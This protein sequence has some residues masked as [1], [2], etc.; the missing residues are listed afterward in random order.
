MLC[1]VERRLKA[2]FVAETGAMSIIL[3]GSP[4]FYIGLK[5]ADEMQS[6]MIVHVEKNH[7]MPAL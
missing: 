5:N 4:F 2:F 7:S 1:G 3:S 6:K